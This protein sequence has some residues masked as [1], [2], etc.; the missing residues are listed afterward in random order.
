MNNKFKI[1][2]FLKNKER[3]INFYNK[4]K[5]RVEF[6]IDIDNLEVENMYFFNNNWE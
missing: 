5:K 3:L 1:N 4:Y 6:S 2:M